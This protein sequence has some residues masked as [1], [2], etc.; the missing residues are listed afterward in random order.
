MRLWLPALLLLAALAPAAPVWTRFRG[1]NGSGV[2]ETG[3]LPVEFGKDKSL[4]WRTPLA[5]GY[6]SP[7][8][9][10]KCVFLTS[11][12]GPKEAL[13]GWTH[14]IDRATGKEL[15]KQ[16]AFTL[17]KKFLSVNTPVSPTPTTDGS[18]V[19]IFAEAAGLLSY[20]ESGKLRWKR[21]L[22]VFN[23]PYS[24][25]ASPVLVGGTL[26]LQADQDTDSYLLAVNAATGETL[27]RRERPE[28]QHGYATPI[29]YKPRQGPE[30]LI[31]SGSYQVAGY[32]VRTGE[33]LWW[34]DGMAWQSK[35]VPV[36]D[37]DMLYVHSWMAELNEIAAKLPKDKPW[38]EF[39]AEND[40]DGDGRISREEAPDPDM[41]KL[42]FLFDLDRSGA[43]EKRDYD[44]IRARTTARSGLFAIE[45][46]GHGDIT[47]K[48]VKWKAEKS[49]PNIPSPLLYKG[50]LY[51]L[52]E[53][54]ILTA[55]NP[56][57]GEIL[58]QGRVEGALD[59]YFASPVAG[60]GKIFTAA[61]DGKIA[62][63][64]AA[65]EWEVLRVNDLE[66]EVWATP[67]IE[68]GNLYIRTQSALYCFG[69]ARE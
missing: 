42:W 10:R 43:I 2:A 52:K 7:V 50:V 30:Q 9:G 47:K 57:T 14:C 59:A 38:E 4:L 67:A 18:N 35:S 29:H 40:K 8:L 31:V 64:K 24:M 55:Y 3:A 26:I 66:E 32:D 60:D 6:S 37:G 20:D 48:A 58:K 49:L 44:I 15:W 16:R 51:I 36:L 5:P 19:Y 63:L 1:P 22:G 21:E 25:A 27:W 69:A 39:L 11:Y 54:G 46:G 61:K 53:G 23:N 34:V 12:D 17:D 45:L 13:L 62:V 56:R 41:P 33:K 65:P 68:D 28:A